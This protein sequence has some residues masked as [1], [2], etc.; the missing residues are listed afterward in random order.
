M[1]KVVHF[2][3]PSDEPQKSMDFYANVFGWKFSKWG[4]EA[5][6][7]VEAG[8]EDAPGINGAIIKKRAPEHPLTNS[9][10][11]TDIDETIEA[12]KKNGCELVV[13]KTEFP[14]VG[15]LAYFKDP[16]GNL[17]G[18]WQKI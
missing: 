10:L 18:I 3:I 2:E 6:W 14:Q 8:P 9:I 7:L 11:V 17:M 4:D 16:D 13:P 5:Y 15:L 12:I 1:A